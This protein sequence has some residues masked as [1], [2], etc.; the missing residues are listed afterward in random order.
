[1]PT[2]GA[3]GSNIAI[4]MALGEISNVWVQDGPR[5]LIDSGSTEVTIELL[6]DQAGAVAL[7]DQFEVALRLMRDTLRSSRTR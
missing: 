6:P 3:D 4:F 5:L 1:M 2:T 7:L